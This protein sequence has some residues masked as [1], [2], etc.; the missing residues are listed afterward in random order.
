MPPKFFITHSWK[1]IEF[2][3]RLTNDLNRHGLAGFFDAYS[4]KP[5]DEIAARIGKGLEECDVYVQLL[6][7]DAVASS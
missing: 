4:I 7:P 2:A 3:T 6:S 1:D 5:G